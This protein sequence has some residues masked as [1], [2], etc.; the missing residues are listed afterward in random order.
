[1]PTT[2]EEVMTP[3]I[4]SLTAHASAREAAEA[5]REAGTG[6]LVV[7]GGETNK[8]FGIL[9]DR[10]IVV[11]VVAEDQDPREVPIGAIC[12]TEVK[13]V[14]VGETPEQAAEL[15]RQHAIRRLPVTDGGSIVGML[16]IGDLARAADAGSVLAGISSAPSNV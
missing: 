3:R 8:F 2:L 10:D 15:M 11:R 5:M 14:D 4:L 13:F 6:S 16:S 7:T 12:S 9:T 1:M